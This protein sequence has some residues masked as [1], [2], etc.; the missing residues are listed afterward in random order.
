M[1]KFVIVPS[2]PC[3]DFFAQFTNCLTYATKEEF[4]G[5][6]YY[7][8]THAPEP[9]TEVYAYALSWEAATQRLEA[10]ACIPKEEAE[11]MEAFLT[12]DD[13][14]IEVCSCALPMVL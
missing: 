5:G 6:I 7:A 9:L 14:A 11:K 2:H 10:A 1:G 12:S 8:I 3:N 4:V 13:A